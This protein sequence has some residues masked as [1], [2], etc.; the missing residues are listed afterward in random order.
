MAVGVTPSSL[1]HCSFS[2]KL[3][4]RRCPR[5]PLRPPAISGEFHV[6]TLQVRQKRTQFPDKPCSGRSAHPLEVLEPVQLA[7]GDGLVER[8]GDGGPVR[9]GGPDIRGPGLGG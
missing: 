3:R 5:Q 2:S 6:D 4:T 9:V 8:A 7:A 1:R